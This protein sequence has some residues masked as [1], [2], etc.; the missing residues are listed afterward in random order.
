MI[1]VTV[2][3]YQEFSDTLEFG[4]NDKTYSIAAEHVQLDF[5]CEDPYD[6]VGREIT[7]NSYFMDQV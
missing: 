4:F 3:N 7:I 2:Q 6:V 5:D 1:K